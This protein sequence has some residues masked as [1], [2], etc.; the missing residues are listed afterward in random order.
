VGR[1]GKGIWK[2]GRDGNE[3]GQE[4]KGMER[5]KEEEGRGIPRMKILAT[6]LPPPA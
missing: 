6:A 3:K 4:G 2:G 1:E 5:E